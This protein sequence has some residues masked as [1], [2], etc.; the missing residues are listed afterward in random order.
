MNIRITIKNSIMGRGMDRI[1]ERLR[2]TG[3]LDKSKVNVLN[4]RS[5]LRLV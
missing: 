3:S 4:N 5:L 2:I 1:G